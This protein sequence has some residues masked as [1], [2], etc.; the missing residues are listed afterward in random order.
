MY[1]FSY[2]ETTQQFIILNILF[3]YLLSSSCKLTRPKTKTLAMRVVYTAHIHRLS[4]QTL[5]YEHRML[6]ANRLNLW[7]L[8]NKIFF[9]AASNAIQWLS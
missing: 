5:H 3:Y 7:N 9:I 2:I 1:L 8:K 6:G 4:A